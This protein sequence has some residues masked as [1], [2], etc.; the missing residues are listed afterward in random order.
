MS[1][2]SR[3]S[4]PAAEALRVEPGFRLADIDPRSTPGYD[5]DKAA[6]KADLDEGREP[7]EDLQERLFAQSVA[8][9]ATGSVLLVL[10]AMDTAGKGGIVRHVVGAVDPQGVELA[11]FKKPTA[12]ELS[13]DF[14]WRIEKRLPDA[15]RLGVFDRS[16]YED[17][18]IGRVRSLA[19]TDEIERRYGAIVTFEAQAAEMGIRVVKVMLHISKDE[20]RERLAERLD[21]PEKHWK[22]NPGDVDERELWDDYMEAYQVAIERT[23]TPVA[24]W[25]VVPAD[26]KWY[27]RLAV[28]QLL[29]GALTHIDPRW[30]AADY[31]VEEEKRRLAAS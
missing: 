6:G 4:T 19:P 10:Q 30:P 2:S 28:Q 18:L 5:G 29:I 16:H 14:L 13:H 20:Q 31:D 27:A 25:H 1:A 21:R 15:G 12:E 3:W 7:L 22:Y 17:V 8:G 23:S 24:P 9:T 26:R 11:S